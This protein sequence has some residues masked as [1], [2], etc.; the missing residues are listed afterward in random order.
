V[1]NYKFVSGFDKWLIDFKVFI[2]IFNK[3][4]TS[5]GFFEGIKQLYKYQK[6]SRNSLKYLT[7]RYIKNKQN[8]IA[9]PD[10]PPLNSVEFADYF[11]SELKYI[12][13]GEKQTLLFA[14]ICISS[15]CPNKCEYCYNISQHSNNE[16]L[17]LEILIKTIK[18]LQD[19]EIKNIYL[20]GGEP[21]MR[22]EDLKIILKS[23][24]DD[25]TGFWLLTTGFQLNKERLI[26]LKNLGL[27]GVMVSL[28]SENELMVNSIKGR[29]NAFN[30]AIN[31]LKSANKTGLVTVIDCVLNK[32]MLDE[33]EFIKFVTFA[34]KLGA[35]FINCYVPRFLNNEINNSKSFTFPEHLQLAKLLKNFNSK[36]KN[37]NLPLIFNPDE[38]EA[39]RGCVGGKSFIY[40]DPEGNVKI[41]P[42]INYSYGNIQNQEIEIILENMNNNFRNNP[43]KI[44]LL[45]NTK[46]RNKN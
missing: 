6:D 19:Q 13:S 31:T 36:W 41:C 22:F 42:F 21:M 20:S 46:V 38:W 1:K 35:H 29:Y 15:Q 2:K 12:N 30:D 23:C 17:S 16:V 27:R 34:G 5:F 28:D 44:N 32:K 26:E 8:I 18:S 25:K 45:L 39:K 3:I 11:L 40:I 9:L 14:I 7:N 24:K 43:C 37:R 33:K 10:L 4:T